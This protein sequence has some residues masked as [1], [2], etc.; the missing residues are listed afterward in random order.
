[1]KKELAKA[2]RAMIIP[3]PGHTLVEFDYT[4]FHVLTTGFEAQDLNY[5]RLAR[6]DMH[7]YVTAHIIRHPLRDK[8]VELPD[9]EL[10]HILGE[11][12]E[13]KRPEY[14]DLFRVPGMG[15]VGTNF[16]RNKQAKPLILGI[17][18]GLGDVHAYEL[19]Q[20]YFSG[21]GEVRV[22]TRLLKHLF[23]P[24]FRW[25][26]DTRA[27]GHRRGMLDTKHGYMRWFPDVYHP[28][29]KN[30]ERL[31]PGADAEKVIAFRPA[32]DAFGHVCDVEIEL[33]ERGWDEKYWLINDIHDAL[34][35]DCPN[36]YVDECLENVG[37]LMV[38]PSKVLVNDAVPGGLWCG[39]EAAVGKE[40]WAR[41]EK[42]E[43][44]RAA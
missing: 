8:L 2:F 39:I 23:E 34:I 3:T 38:Q 17:G 19:N 44:G 36:R 10:A 18:F 7:S 11:I 30:R 43:L 21:I 13:E 24:V 40:S 37:W 26:D 42:V 20:E 29:P 12:K 35:F 9:A 32:N 5:M 1:M 15:M 33:G 31:V 28:D 14:K 16:I 4:A 22:I 41:M 6:L 27:E 25:Q